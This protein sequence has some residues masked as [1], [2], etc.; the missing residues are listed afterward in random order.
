M[1]LTDDEYAKIVDLSLKGLPEGRTCSHD[2]SPKPGMYL[3]ERGERAYR[4]V[5]GRVPPIEPRPD[6]WLIA[7]L[8]GDSPNAFVALPNT[9]VTY[10]DL[11]YEIHSRNLDA[12]AMELKKQLE[13]RG[14]TFRDF[15][16]SSARRVPRRGIVRY[17]HRMLTGRS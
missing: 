16:E 5:A 10:F 13:A 15:P 4:I 11:K 12:F 14:C 1:L 7:I 6:E 9:A 2:Q 3:I 17:M 8:W